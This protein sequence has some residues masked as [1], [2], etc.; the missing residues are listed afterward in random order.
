M[1]MQR[2]LLLLFVAIGIAPVASAGQQPSSHGVV[3]VLQAVRAISAIVVDGKLDDEVWQRTTAA[4]EFTQREPNEGAPATEA[5]ELRIAYDNNA[6]YVGVRLKDRE[7][8]RIARQLARRDQDAEADSF[9]VILDPHHDHLT[10]ASFGVSAAGVQQDATVYNDT[11]TDQ[12]WDAVWESAVRMDEEGWSLEMRIPYSQLRFPSADRLTFGITAM[13]FIQRKKEQDWLVHVPKTESGLASRMAHLEGLNGVSPRRTVAFLPYV[14]SRA[15]FL[16]R[17]SPVDPLNDGARGVAGL[18]VD[19]KYR[20]SSNLSLDGTIN[21]DFGQ[22]EVD[23][24]V[25][26]L[27][28]FETFYEEKRPF[29]IEGANIFSNFGQ[30]GANNFWGFNRSEPLLFYSRRI[31]RSPQGSANGDFVDMPASTTILGA[32]KLTGRTRRGWTVGVLDAVTDSEHAETVSGGVSGTTEVEPLSNYFVFRAQR[33]LTKRAGIGAIA[34]AVNRKFSSPAVADELPEQSYV[35]GVDGHYFLDH[36]RNWVLNG[37]FAGSSVRGSTGA[38]TQLQQASQR[39]FDRPDATHLELDPAATSLGGWTGAINLNRQSGVHLTNLS[40]WAV[41]PGMDSSDAGFTFNSDRGGMHGVYQWRS[42]KVTDHFRDRMLAIAKFYTWNFGREL[43]SDGLFLFGNAQLKNYW[44]IFAN[45]LY[46]RGV[47]DDRATR[48]GPSMAQ[49]SAGSLF[50]GVQS[51]SR[52]R[53]RLSVD[54]GYDRNTAGAWSLNSSINLRYIPSSSLEIS[55]GPSLNLNY[56]L[57]QYVDRIADPVAAAT[58]GARYLFATLDQRQFSLQT[59]VNYV[60]SPKMSLQVYLQPLVSVGDY[61][62]FKEFAQ[63]RTFDFTRYG[64]DRGAI[65]YRPAAKQYTVDPGDGGAPFTFDNPDFNFKS[66][67]LN[68]IFRWEWKPGSTMYVV[69]TEQR[70]DTTHPGEFAFRRDFRAT[71]GAPADD[72]LMFKIAYWFQR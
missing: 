19:L 23:P 48:G 16:E 22:V 24:A 6:L 51:D 12:S 37:R 43:Q 70:E 52:R 63:P 69:W 26:N 33:E 41:S 15:E 11:F 34:T 71:F 18:G 1:L 44:G 8:A 31:G 57:A 14:V 29:F 66:L 7:P 45:A 58:Y 17:S 40:L 38:I 47:Q 25:V 20:F 67:R 60:L 54:N 10:G 72:V 42:P 5:T 21:P 64:I 65:S 32:A 59:R 35:T 13:R 28:A 50:F 62:E 49:P 9:T 36:K 3:P 2:A 39:Y 68:A 46:F 30:T 4:T 53:L 55:S 56:N 27:T 61:G